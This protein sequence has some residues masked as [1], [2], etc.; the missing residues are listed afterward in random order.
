M[1]SPTDSPRACSSL[2][3]STLNLWQARKLMFRDDFF[4]LLYMLQLN[5]AMD[6]CM[7]CDVFFFALHLTVE[8]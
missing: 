6:D 7:C 8:R 5:A 4:H 1:R 3:N 2:E